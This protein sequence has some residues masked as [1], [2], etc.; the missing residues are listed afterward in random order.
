MEAHFRIS[1]PFLIVRIAQHADAPP[2][3]LTLPSYERERAEDAGHRSGAE[4]YA[5]T[6]PAPVLLAQSALNEH[7]R[8]DER[9]TLKSP[10]RFK[11][12]TWGQESHVDGIPLQDLR[13]D[14]PSANT[15]ATHDLVCVQFSDFRPQSPNF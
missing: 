5:L 9:R 14:I 12:L 10:T 2:A 4:S 6:P 3:T 13:S 15:K 11:L 1:T 7:A 8:R